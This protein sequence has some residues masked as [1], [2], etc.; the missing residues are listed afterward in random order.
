M[1]EEKKVEFGQPIDGVHWVKREE[2][3]PNNYNPNTVF[4]KEL[5]LIERSILE[6]GWTCPIVV[7]RS[8]NSIVDGFHRWQISERPKMMERFQG[9]VAVVYISPSQSQKIAATV[10]HNRARGVHGVSKMRDIVVKLI[11]LGLEPFQ[12]Q[13]TLGME[14]EE[15]ERYLETRGM[16]EVVGDFEIWGRAWEP[17]KK[18]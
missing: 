1:P 4:S 18:S 16:P 6:T 2:L 8:D 13:E 17:R 3:N 7:D 10:R 15:V 9:Y 11:E 12:V 14:K 5:D